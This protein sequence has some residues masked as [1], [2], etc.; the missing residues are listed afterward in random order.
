MLLKMFFHFYSHCTIIGAES[1]L[2]SSEIFWAEFGESCYSIS[3]DKMDFNLAHHHHHHQNLAFTMSF[4]LFLH[5]QKLM[6]NLL[7]YV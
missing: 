3:K 5:L 1:C 7:T 2:S 6:P 4:I